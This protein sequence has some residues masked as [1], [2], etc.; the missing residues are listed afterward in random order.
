[1]V[2]VLRRGQNIPG[3]ALIP[4]KGAGRTFQERGEGIKR[5][6]RRNLGKER[7]GEDSSKRNSDKHKF[8]RSN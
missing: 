7:G 1:M 2:V 5:E 4:D 3:K 8:E 6:E